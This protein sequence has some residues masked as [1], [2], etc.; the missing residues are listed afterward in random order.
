[1]PENECMYCQLEKNHKAY[2]RI[3]FENDFC[4]KHKQV[5]QSKS[6]PLDYID[7]GIEIEREQNQIHSEHEEQ[8]R[9]DFPKRR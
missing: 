9:R 1:M 6:N 2:A 4:E 3:G 8:D 7:D 5:P